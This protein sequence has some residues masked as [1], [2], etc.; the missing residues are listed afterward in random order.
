MLEYYFAA[1]LA[2]RQVGDLAYSALPD[3]PDQPPREDRR[4]GRNRPSQPPPAADHSQVP[5]SVPAE[6][7]IAVGSNGSSTWDPGPAGN[8]GSVARTAMA[9]WPLVKEL[10]PELDQDLNAWETTH[11]WLYR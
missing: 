1:M 6:V 11:G 10:F 4:R 3:A 9:A 7:P 5:A 8:G 2:R